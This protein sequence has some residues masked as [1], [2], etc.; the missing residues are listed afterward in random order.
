MVSDLRLGL[1]SNTWDEAEFHV[2]GSGATSIRFLDIT[3]GGNTSGN[4]DTIMHFSIDTGGV[5][6]VVAED[7]LQWRG[8]TGPTFGNYFL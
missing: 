6:P 4:G 7:E 3:M 8:T 5:T 1:I 2:V